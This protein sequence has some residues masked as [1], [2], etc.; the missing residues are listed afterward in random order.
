MHVAA[1]AAFVLILFAIVGMGMMGGG[2]M[3]VGWHSSMAHMGWSRSAATGA[4]QAP[5]AGACDISHPICLEGGKRR[6]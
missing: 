2:G 5:V 1:A 4:A 3:P 6:W